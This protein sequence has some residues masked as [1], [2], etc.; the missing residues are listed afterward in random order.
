MNA[1]R[2]K[3][4]RSAASR[5]PSAVSVIFTNLR[6]TADLL[7]DLDPQGSA[8]DWHRTATAAGTP[9]TTADKALL[10]VDVWEHAYYIDYRN[11]RQKFVETFLNNMANWRFAEGN[12]A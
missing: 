5:S 11:L 9:L 12:F 8:D 6:E 2:S 7:V 10:T 4:D 3:V 1:T